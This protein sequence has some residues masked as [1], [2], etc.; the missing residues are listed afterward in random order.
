[1]TPKQR[2]K[3]IGEWAEE[4]LKKNRT[5]GKRQ[6]FRICTIRKFTLRN[7]RT[8]KQN[9]HKKNKHRNRI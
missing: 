3:E 9:P 4:E 5:R 8:R 1:M 6:F 2:I 7:R